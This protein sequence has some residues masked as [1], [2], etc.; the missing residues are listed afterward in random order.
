M[1][2]GTGLVPKFTVAERDRRWSRVRAL[3][4]RDRVDAIFVPPHTGLFDM[5]Q[6]NVRYLTGIGGNHAM[7]AA[8]FPLEGQ[9]TAVSSPDVHKDI[10]LERQDWVS[11]I[12]SI[13]S[14]W[15]FTGEVVSRI[16]EMGGVKRLGVT[17][18]SGNTRFPEGTT[19][20][21]IVERLREALPGVELVNVNPLMEEA[22]FVKSDEEIAFLQAGVGLVEKAIDVLA[23]EA[24]PGVAENVAYARMLASIV[25]GGG[26]LP[27]MILW[28]SGNP[29]PPS[30]YYM[31]TR[32]TFE[33]GDII[34]TEAEARWGGYIAQNTQALFLGKA[35]A[36]LKSMFE[37]QQDAIALCYEMLRPG[38][39]IG[40]LADAV[41]AKSTNEYECSIL[42]HGRGLGDDSPIAI[43]KPRD[44]V[45]AK[46]V[47]QEKS[48]FIIK[49]LIRKA[50]S[51]K[52]IYWGDTVVCTERGARRLGSRPPAIIEIE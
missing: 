47:I 43:Y 19:S 25:E 40:E 31:P 34:L 33:R 36:E 10:W 5:F 24:R 8:I 39:T 23:A 48:A 35:D 45:M 44:D 1:G 18:L 41:A 14:G 3:M 30:N 51:T 22:R 4:T 49:P 28:S 32:R 27:S 7:A 9:V 50:G 15:G 6:A 17:G 38:T 37:R 26:E 12:R 21:G 20:H 2:S 16:R 46:W 11:D 42:I 13:S 29:Q 52:R